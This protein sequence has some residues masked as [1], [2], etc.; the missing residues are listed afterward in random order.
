[1]IILIQGNGNLERH[2][3]AFASVETNHSDVLAL[4]FDDGQN[5]VLV[6]DETRKPCGMFLGGRNLGIACKAARRRLALELQQPSL[7]GRLG[8]T[9]PD[10]DV[11]P[12]FQLAGDG[13]QKTKRSA[14]VGE[15]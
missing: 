12:G 6:V 11:L 3:S 5:S 9:Q 8:K 13:G 15:G 14:A 1:M 7:V 4:E 2:R 10:L